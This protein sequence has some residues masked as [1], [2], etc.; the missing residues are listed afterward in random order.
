MDDRQIAEW[1]TTEAPPEGPSFDDDEPGATRPREPPAKA[2]QA[3]CARPAALRNRRGLL[4]SV[5]LDALDAFEGHD[6]RIRE[7]ID[8]VG[9][10]IRRRPL[11][12]V[13]LGV[14]IGFV[15][16]GA[17][18]FRAGRILLAAGARGAARGL[19]KQLL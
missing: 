3:H 2:A 4:G 9:R 6:P 7:L 1:L 13:V 8:A 14:G 16:G 11:A 5:G 18:S 17:L 15:I 10:G 19:L 12:A